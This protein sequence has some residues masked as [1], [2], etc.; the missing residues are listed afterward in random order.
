MQTTFNFNIRPY[1]S[2]V[3][4]AQS[5]SFMFPRRARHPHIE[6]QTLILGEDLRHGDGR[7]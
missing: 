6:P 7:A 2:T 4:G 5:S 3:P 1:S